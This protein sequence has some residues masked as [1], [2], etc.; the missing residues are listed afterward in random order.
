MHHTKEFKTYSAEKKT[1]LI[2]ALIIK[3]VVFGAVFAG[4]YFLLKNY[5]SPAPLFGLL[6]ILVL[7]CVLGFLFIHKRKDKHTHD[8]ECN[9]EVK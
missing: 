7:A 3:L 5:I 4:L 6:H 2:I 1:R 9:C 8:Q